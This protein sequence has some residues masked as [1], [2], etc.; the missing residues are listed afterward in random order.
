MEP[1]EEGKNV[2]SCEEEF[3]LKLLKL[4]TNFEL[5]ALQTLTSESL[6]KKYSVLQ[7]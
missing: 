7:I 6:E 5:F 3:L 4:L 1:T 2:I